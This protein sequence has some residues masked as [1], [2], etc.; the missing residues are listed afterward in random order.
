MIGL[1]ADHRAEGDER[2]V[3]AGRGELLERERHF[4]SAGHVADRHVFLGHAELLELLQAVAI[5][6][7]PRILVE[8][9]NHN[10]NA[11]ASSVEVLGNFINGH[12]R[13]Q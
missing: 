8:A 11:K 13:L 1:A 5:L 9:R 4:Q 7:A 12:R 3:L 2:V 10:A 6:L